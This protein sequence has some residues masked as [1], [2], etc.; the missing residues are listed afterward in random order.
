M[1][2]RRPGAG[3]STAPAWDLSALFNAADPAAG[4]A[5]RHLWL[6]RLIEWLR[7]DPQGEAREDEPTALREPLPVRRLQRLLDVLE[8]NDDQRARVAALLA[9]CWNEVDRVALFADFGFSTRMNLLGELGNRLRDKLLPLSPATH[10]L[11]ELFPLLFSRRGDAAWLAAI[12][13]ETA[14]RIGRL[15]APEIDAQP[16]PVKLGG[17]KHDL[18]D[19]IVFISAAVGA[20][21]FSPP[22]RQR[23]S[24]E[25]LAGAPFRQIT[26]AAERVHEHA[27]QGDQAALL[28]EGQYLR[29]LLDA[30]R[31]AAASVEQHFEEHGVSVDVVFELD[32]LRERTRRIEELLNCVLSDQPRRDVVRLIADLADTAEQRRSIRALF[33]QHYS[34]LARKVAERN[35]ET[36]EH[37][38]TRDRSAWRQMLQAALGGGAVIAVTTFAKLAL[39]ATGVAG[40]WGGLVVGVNYA[41]SFVAVQ[42]LHW[43]IATKQPA[44]TAPAMAAKLSGVS[45]ATPRSRASSTRWRR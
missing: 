14:L 45:S 42:L 38:I 22:I 13:D 17:W 15:I 5:E 25:L 6:V 28:R 44:M 12:D 7:H 29:A 4:F 20:A 3:A 39:T 19:A 26:R 2:R 21:G 32:Q 33:A 30:C 27:R 35:A 34:L 24:R 37:Y 31:V 23:M 9:R 11:A 36:G 43:T 8:R 40:F 18:L 1:I 41:L 10:D 16:W